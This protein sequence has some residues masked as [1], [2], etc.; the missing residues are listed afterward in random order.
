MP[1]PLNWTENAVLLEFNESVVDFFDENN[2]YYGNFSDYDLELR[3]SLAAHEP[4]MDS[5]RD[6]MSMIVVTTSILG[7]IINFFILIISV[8][9]IR[10]DYRLFIANLAA[11]DIV[12]G[13]FLLFMLC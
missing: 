12:C 1:L 3:Q 2:D 11:V 4:N 7:L 9:N 5:F 8:W 10:G 6:L 13:L